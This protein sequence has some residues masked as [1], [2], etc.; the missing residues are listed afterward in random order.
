MLGISWTID[1]LTNDICIFLNALARNQGYLGTP[2]TT[3]D[4]GTHPIFS[5]IKQIMMNYATNC[6]ANQ[7]NTDSLGANQ[8]LAASGASLIS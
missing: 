4:N 5:F 3:S 7:L 1:T 2:I 6:V 8:A